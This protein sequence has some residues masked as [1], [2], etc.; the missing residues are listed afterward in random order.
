MGIYKLLDDKD[1]KR[2]IQINQEGFLLQ[3]DEEIRSKRN[4]ESK[5]TTRPVRPG[6]DSHLGSLMYD[7]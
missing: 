3:D 6:S 2:N 7:L 1:L 5:Q 4:G